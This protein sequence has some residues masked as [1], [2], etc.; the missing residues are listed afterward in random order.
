MHPKVCK[1]SLNVHSRNIACTSKP[2][3]PLLLVPGCIIECIRMV[4]SQE[5]GDAKELAG[6][7]GAEELVAFFGE[8]W[9]HSLVQVVV[10]SC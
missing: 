3:A 10:L 2:D 4:A 9:V 5:Q 8:G 6:I 1:F 7:I